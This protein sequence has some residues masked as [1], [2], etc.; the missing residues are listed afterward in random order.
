M[1][2]IDHDPHESALVADR[3]HGITDLVVRKC[4]R[5]ALRAVD[6]TVGVGRQENLVQPVGLLSHVDGGLLRAMSREMQIDEVAR[7]D[8][9]GEFGQLPG[10]GVVRRGFQRAVQSIGE[11][12]YVGGF[13][14]RRRIL[15]E[16]GAHQPDVV[17]RPDKVGALEIRI[18]RYRDQKGVVG[19]R[20]R[21]RGG[22]NRSRERDRG[23][24]QN[25]V[26]AFENAHSNVSQAH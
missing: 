15:F 10:N 23:G 11:Y 6:P 1:A 8:R 7:C 2:C 12:P 14:L 20:Q 17:V 24:R 26:A 19:P 4:G 9:F 3:L 25:T 21:R 18:F 13:E 5:N 22:E 16:E